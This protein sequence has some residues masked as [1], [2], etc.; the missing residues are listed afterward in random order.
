MCL[1][2]LIKQTG[3][4]FF[5]PSGL[6]QSNHP[7]TAFY[8]D[9]CCAP[10]GAWTVMET[11]Y[12]GRRSAAAPLRF[13]PGSIVGPLRGGFRTSKTLDK[14]IR[15]GHNKRTDDPGGSGSMALSKRYLW[16]ERVDELL[17]H[18]DVTKIEFCGRSWI[19]WARC[20]TTPVG[21]AFQPDTDIDTR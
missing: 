13:A 9:S 4:M 19:T 20:A 21:Q 3:A 5:R 12:P 6:T 2:K 7:E 8:V 15:I 10:V 14:R 11:A 1:P 16:G 17:A 18:E